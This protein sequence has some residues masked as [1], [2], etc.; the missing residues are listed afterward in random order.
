M[1]SEYIIYEQ[2][3]GTLLSDLWDDMGLE[4][5]INIVHQL[6][7]IEKKMLSASLSR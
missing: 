3:R 7:A 1:E 4:M 6:I 5:K 2:A